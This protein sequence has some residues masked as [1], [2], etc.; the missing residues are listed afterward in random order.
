MFLPI[1][2]A[3]IPGNP[4]RGGCFAG[5]SVSAMWTRVAVASMAVGELPTTWSPQGSSCDSI[6]INLHIRSYLC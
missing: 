5:L 3:R 4:L 1:D 6:S 2:R